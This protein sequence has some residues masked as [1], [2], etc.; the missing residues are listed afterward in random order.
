[1]TL[2]FTNTREQD[3]S[4]ISLGA[5]S[6]Y[7][8]TSIIRNL[9]DIPDKHRIESHGPSYGRVSS[10]MDNMVKIFVR[11]FGV[12]FSRVPVGKRPQGSDGCLLF[13]LTDLTRVGFHMQNNFFSKIMPFG[14]VLSRHC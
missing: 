14:S 3:L 9:L 5:R 12:R 13:R 4:A 7:I 1:M 8:L 6:T 10:G 2:R 11:Y